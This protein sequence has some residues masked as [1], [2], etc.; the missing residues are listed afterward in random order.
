MPK[1]L[2]VLLLLAITLLATQ[3]AWGMPAVSTLQLPPAADATL[4]VVDPDANVGLQPTLAFTYAWEFNQSAGGYCLTL[5]KTFLL[6]FDLSTVPFPIDKARLRLLPT[7]MLT[8]A[9]AFDLYGA[10]DGWG[11]ATVTWN[12]RPGLVAGPLLPPPQLSDSGYVYFEDSGTPIPFLLAAWLEGERSGDGVATLSVALPAAAGCT[13][14]QPTPSTVETLFY[15]RESV[16]VPILDL[17]ASGSDLPRLP[18]PSAVAL[19]RA[20]TVPGVPSTLLVALTL[21]IGGTLLLLAHE[22]LPRDRTRR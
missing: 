22:H 18:D 13:L 12:S 5:R 11:E 16:H 6:Q 1:R 8:A 2:I 15:S 7:L 4:M 9:P 10:A 20:A 14:V 17:A 21:L 3:A 19:R